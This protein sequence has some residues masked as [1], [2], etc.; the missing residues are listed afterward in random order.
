[1]R[2]K[3]LVPLIAGLAQVVVFLFLLWQLHHQVQD[4]DW[5]DAAVTAGLVVW[6]TGHATNGR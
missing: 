2:D 4:Q 6:V 3:A 1:M 5:P